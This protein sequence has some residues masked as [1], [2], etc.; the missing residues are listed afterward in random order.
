MEERVRLY[1]GSRFSHLGWGGC[2]NAEGQALGAGVALGLSFV[3]SE[4]VDSRLT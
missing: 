4:G 2:A 1:K 3:F